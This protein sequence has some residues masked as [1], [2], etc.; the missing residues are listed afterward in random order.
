[1][2]IIMR[3][4]VVADQRR[5]TVASRISAPRGVLRRGLLATA[6][7]VLAMP[8]PSVFAQAAPPAVRAKVAAKPAPVAATAAAPAPASAPPA[9][10]PVTTGRRSTSN[11]AGEVVARMGG[12]EIREGALRAFLA[13]LSEGDR[14]AIRRD[15]EAMARAVRALLANQ[16][17][18]TEATTRH[19]EQ[20]PAIAQ[21]LQQLRDNAIVQSYLASVSNPPQDYPTE[22]ELQA[23]YD[24]NKSA[25]LIPR[26]YLVAQIFIAASKDADKAS[27]DRARAKI[28]DIARQLKQPNADFAAIARASSEARQSAEKGGEIG[29]L[30][31]TQLRPDIK[32]QVISLAKGET[33]APVQLEDGWQILK[34]NDTRPAS[35]PSFAEVHDALRQRIRDERAAELRR[36]YLADLLKQNP[37]AINE[38]VVS[39]IAGESAQATTR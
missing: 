36:G 14:A 22:A 23:A 21:Q 8:T 28:D 24:A 29:W 20:Q 7:V 34:L 16:Q 35:T 30:A 15:P 39:K 18:L 10:E 27:Q 31:E 19:W 32:A 4:A 5:D 26:Q 38:L 11:D 2:S 6:F 17:V 25:F 9:S 3:H 33:S 1:M 13:G 37:P 12:I